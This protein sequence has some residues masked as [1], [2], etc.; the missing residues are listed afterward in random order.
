MSEKQTLIESIENGNGR[1]VRIHL[2]TFK[3]KGY[4][5]IRTWIEGDDG[6]WKAT[7]KGLTLHTELLPALIQ[8]LMK[9]DESLEGKV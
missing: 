6:E 7:P 5:D 4:V 9:A 1:S 8:A 2:Q 3:G